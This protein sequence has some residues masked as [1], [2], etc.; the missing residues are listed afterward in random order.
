M[1]SAWT[2]LERYLQ[3]APPPATMGDPS[4]IMTGPTSPSVGMAA[5]ASAA[6]RKNI[7]LLN[8]ELDALI[9]ELENP[10]TP[11]IK[12]VDMKKLGDKLYQMKV[13]K[14]SPMGGGGAEDGE[15]GAPQETEVEEVY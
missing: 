10:R 12:G 5:K 8:V 1:S 4:S 9:Q 11:M 3:E 2:I 14:E 15:A 7:Q 13:K 6:G